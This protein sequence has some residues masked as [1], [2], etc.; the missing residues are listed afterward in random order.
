MKK[1]EGTGSGSELV[2]I[3]RVTD[4]SSLTICDKNGIIP[5][6]TL[7]NIG[8][9]KSYNKRSKFGKLLKILYLVELLKT[10]LQNYSLVKKR[11]TNI[12]G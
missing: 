2:E 8:T 10:I 9:G 1:D 4:I 12:I 11:K 3:S 5:L 7:T 6:K